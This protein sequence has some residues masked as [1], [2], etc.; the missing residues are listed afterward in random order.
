MRIPV[1]SPSLGQAEADALLR[2]ITEGHASGNSPIVREFEAAFAAASGSAKALAVSS[3]STALHLAFDA[4]GLGPGDEV[5]VPSFTFAPCADMAVLTGATV[6]FADSEPN[7]FNISA[8]TI[9]PLIT[10]RTRAVL[11]VHLYG[12]PCDMDPI[13]A[14]CEGRQI[15]VI[16]D[17]AQALGA[18][19][20]GRPVGTMGA[21]GCYSFYANKHIT[22]GEGG[23]V[24]GPSGGLMDKVKWLRSHALTQDIAPY[25]HS[26][27]AYNYRMPAFAAAVGLAQTGQLPEFQATRDAN[28]A[29]YADGLAQIEGVIW[30]KTA[31]YCSKH[32][33]WA[34]A[35]LFPGRQADR[36]ANTLRD[37]D[38]DTRPFYSAL[39]QHVAYGL[40]D[41]PSLSVA[42]RIATEGLVLPSGHNL[43]S[44]QVSRV[45]D[46]V[47]SALTS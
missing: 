9:A 10:D 47:R 4:I 30:P 36:I 41:H 1:H 12:H 29:Q 23:A 14:L 13:L 40:T 20:K 44:N 43:T 6:V 15:A 27:V 34:S 46:A 35:V 31:D 21:L 8:E 3:G 11:A 2:C 19:Y 26:A 28:A 38:V 16:E 5:I 33:R 22:T 42:E 24:V 39:H 17:C 32:A 25:H 37:N 18:H 45:C 7:H